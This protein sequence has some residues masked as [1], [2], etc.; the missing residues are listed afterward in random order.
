MARLGESATGKCA[1]LYSQPG[2]GLELSAW[3]LGVHSAS[4][5]NPLLAAPANR[6]SVSWQACSGASSRMLPSGPGQR[7]EVSKGAC[8]LTSFT[9]TVPAM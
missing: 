7:G 2:K 4:L 3:E 8:R 5:V 6:N 9:G 1:N